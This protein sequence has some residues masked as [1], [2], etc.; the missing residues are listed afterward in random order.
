[1]RVGLKHKGTLPH[2]QTVRDLVPRVE[3]F[4]EE[5]TKDLLDVSFADLSLAVLVA[6]DDVRNTLQEAEQALSE[7]GQKTCVSKRASCI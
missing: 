4:C 1:M 5:V 6:D 7:G 3:A 2:A